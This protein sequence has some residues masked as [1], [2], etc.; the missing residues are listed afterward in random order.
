MKKNHCFFFGFFIVSQLHCLVSLY[1]NPSG[2]SISQGTAHFENT[3][4]TTLMITTSEKS[5][6]FWEDLSIAEGELTEIIQ[7]SSDCCVVIQVENDSPSIISGTL[8]SNG[9][10]F[11]INPNGIFIETGGCVEASAFTASTLPACACT[12][13]SGTEEVFFQGESS[14]AVINNGRIKSLLQDTCLIGHQIENK[15]A[16]DAP[17]G[18]AILAAGNHVIWKP[19][20]ERKISLLLSL[21]KDGNKETG[22]D[23]SGMITASKA[24]LCADGNAYSVAIR[25][26]GLIDVVSLNGQNAEVYLNAENGNSGIF[27]AIT[28]ENA[29][30]T[31]G[32]IQ[33]LGKNVALFENSTID[34]SGEN[35]GGSIFIGQSRTGFNATTTLVDEEVVISV[36]AIKIGNGG[37]VIV[38]AEEMT[39]FYGTV[40]ACGGEDSGNGGFIEIFSK[41]KLDFQ[42]EVDHFAPR[43]KTG[44]L[45]LYQTQ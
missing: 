3:D 22:I 34:A 20:N 27:G 44:S 40:S 16:I 9:H 1:A 13:L 28:A 11:L 14:N 43:G 38:G 7:P 30:G 31:G 23:N 33:I 25:H 42:G 18:T 37:K 41:H 5:H 39:C 24:V 2:P 35:G 4:T 15:G 10:L 32:T 29:D 8:K 36:D 19:G 6:I 12:L 26:A 21:L 45:L 17:L